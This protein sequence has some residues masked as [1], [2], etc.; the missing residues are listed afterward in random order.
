M[1]DNYLERKMDELRNRRPVKTIARA[2]VY[3]ISGRERNAVSLSIP[4]RRV[5]VV[6]GASG[7]VAA[8][9][10]AYLRA[11]CKVAVFDSPD[12]E[13]Q[14]M[15][16]SEGVRFHPVD[17]SEPVSLTSAFTT[18]LKAWRDIDIVIL[19]TQPTTPTRID[20]LH[21]ITL[22]WAD[23]R[24][25]FPIPSDY[26]FRL[27]NINISDIPNTSVADGDTDMAD[28]CMSQIH[29]D[30]TFL[31]EPSRLS[32]LSKALTDTC[33]FLSLPSISILTSSIV[34]S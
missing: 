34:I 27:I 23:H 25:R 20:S 28:I 24:R 2:P 6:G 18:L 21:D 8:L 31:T 9:T 14:Q 19:P 29:V 13:G 12:S 16:Y 33:L 7:I 32:S 15:A 10:R 4:G 11:G 1:A 3:A 30:P 5:L 17:L 22:L 26:G